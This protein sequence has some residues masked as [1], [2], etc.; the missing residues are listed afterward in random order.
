MW[1]YGFWSFVRLNALFSPF[2]RGKMIMLLLFSEFEYSVLSH[3]IILFIC[4]IIREIGSDKTMKY[5]N[6]HVS[7]SDIIIE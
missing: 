6:F 1:K 5:C 4:S 3:I 2:P 7:L